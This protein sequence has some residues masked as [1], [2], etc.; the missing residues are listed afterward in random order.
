MY[1]VLRS[2]HLSLSLFLPLPLRLYLCLLLLLSMLAIEF[3]RP[4]ST[5]CAAAGGWWYTLAVDQSSCLNITGCYEPN[6][7]WAANGILTSKSPTECAACGGT[8]TPWFQWISV[9]RTPTLP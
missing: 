1:V 7:L 9:R 2:I 8:T 4:Q 6:S 5:T 3:L